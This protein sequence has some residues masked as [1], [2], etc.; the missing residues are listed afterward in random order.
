MELGKRKVA[1][2][3]RLKP[4]TLSRNFYLDTSRT[5]DQEPFAIEADTRM[6]FS[7]GTKSNKIFKNSMPDLKL[8]V[9][10]YKQI[11]SEYDR[12]IE[13]GFKN[14]SFENVPTFR[15]WIKDYAMENYGREFSDST[16]KRISPN[17]KIPS[18]E[19]RIN[20]FRQL[21]DEA[22]EGFVFKQRVDLK[23]QA[24]LATGQATSEKKWNVAELDSAADKHK[25][26]FQFLSSDPS[27]PVEELFDFTQ[28]VAELTGTSKGESSKTLNSLK[29]YQ[30]FKPVLNRLNVTASKAALV[31]KGLT[32]GDVQDIISNVGESGFRTSIAN[33]PEN[34]IL[35]SV[36]R[37]IKQGGKQIRW[38]KKPGDV[39]KAGDLITD[40]DTVFNFKGKN[41]SYDDLL[42]KGRDLGEFKDVYKAYDDLSDLLSRRTVHPVT[43]Q[44]ILFGDLMKEAYNKGAGYSYVMSPYQADHFKSVKDSPFSD[45]RIIPRRQNVAQGALKNLGE[46]QATGVMK[47]EQYTPEFVEF[48]KEKM[49]YNYTKNMNQLFQD[50]M[51]LADDVLVKGRELKTP[52]NIAKQRYQAVSTDAL[53]AIGCPNGF[54]SGGRVKF[55]EGDSCVRKGIEAIKSGELNTAQLN[56]YESVLKKSGTLTDDAAKVLKGAKKVGKLG[57]KA[58]LDFI[59]VGSGPVGLAIGTVVELGLGYDKLNRG[60]V[61]GFVRD[62][63]FGLAGPSEREELLN[64]AQTEEEKTALTNLFDYQDK[65]DQANELESKINKTYATPVEAMAEETSE[66]FDTIKGMKDLAQIDS[67]LAADYSKVQ[68]IDTQKLVDTVSERLTRQKAEKLS[69]LYGTFFGNRADRDLEKWIGEAK[70]TTYQEDPVT[71]YQKQAGQTFNPITIDPETLMLDRSTFSNGSHPNPEIQRLLDLI[72]GLMIADFVPEP[73][74]AEIR[75]LFNDFNN[76]HMKSE[77]GRI[78]FSNGPEDPKFASRRNFL[79]LMT[80]LAALPV[81][82]KYIKIAKPVAKILPK[83]DIVQVPGMPTFYSKM[84]NDALNYG[85]DKTKELGTIEREVVKQHKFGEYGVTVSHQLDTGDVKVIVDGTEDTLFGDSVEMIY[86]SP[87]KTESGEIIP[88]DFKAVEAEVSGN[89]VGPDDYEMTFEGSYTTEDSNKL[90]SNLTKLEE[91]VTG[92]NISTRKN[93]VREERKKYYE[94]KQGQ[95][96]VLDEK[97]GY[98]DD[99]QPEDLIDE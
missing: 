29:K 37:H 83:V 12:V 43:K 38:V 2:S 67:E 7:T 18:Q 51:N 79:K 3:F 69:G 13:D 70:Q 87:K 20:L 40:R 6:E 64:A 52:I 31:N 41:Y 1:M 34:F 48:G 25:K 97:Y 91:A 16:I 82:G 86:R 28:K 74:K 10:L 27:R 42:T 98:F 78:G 93:I 66:S 72:D 22:N 15:E 8:N 84:V 73:E 44:E 56:A 94:S 85:V 36:E 76:R 30:D 71:A 80:A 17:L 11:A 55:G 99:T 59:S 61:S 23:K 88:A 26:A 39:T 58:L 77:G 92:K 96:Q 9:D 50:E 32:L 49:G 57:G 89:R 90:G 4:N 62:F 54:M 19:A 35:N 46:R 33:T 24:G 95:E 14:K 21:V 63:T 5:L 68:N 53:G 75:R 45:I 65:Y 81:V 60:D 47:T